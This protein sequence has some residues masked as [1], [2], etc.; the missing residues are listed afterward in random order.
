MPANLRPMKPEDKPSLME[1]L[2]ATP[3]FKSYEVT[4]AEEVI[5]TYLK[6]PKGSG[7]HIIV[8]DGAAGVDGYI[9]YG[10]TPCTDGTWDFYWEAVR[11]EKRGK[12]IGS[13]LSRAAEA[14]VR[15][16]RGRLILVE[17]SSTPGYENTRRFHHH[18]GFEAVGRIPDFYSPGDDRITMQK[19]LK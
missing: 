8:A 17:T 9:C 13:A 19:R 6:D 3:E 11:R 15:K 16:A 5:D 12:G 14:A 1:L 7:Y 2:R 4:V 10:P 18:H